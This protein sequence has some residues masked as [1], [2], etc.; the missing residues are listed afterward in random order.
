MKQKYY[1]A[2]GGVVVHEGKMLLL[3]RP[4]RGEVRLPKGHIDP[5]EFPQETALRE[6]TE[7]S[8][9]ADLTII[10]D[11]GERQTEFDF[12]GKHVVR[13]E[14]YY[15]MRLNSDATARR[16]KKDAAQFNVLWLPV[17][18]APAAL[19]YRAEQDVAQRALD[20]L[21]EIESGA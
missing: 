20:V 11:L 2:A 8:G 16:S 17:E 6:T 3:D 10:G 18:S 15:L 4:S 9:Y 19:T 13:T 1:R 12:D 14:Y 5:G 21:A 7:E